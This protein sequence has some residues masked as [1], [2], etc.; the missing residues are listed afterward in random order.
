MERRIVSRRIANGSPLTDDSLW[1]RIPGQNEF[2]LADG[3]SQAPIQTV[4]QMGWDADNLYVRFQCE[5]EDILSEYTKRD[6]PLYDQEVAEL[7]LAPR[8]RCRYFEFNVSPRNVQFDSLVVN[9]L[10]GSGYLGHPEWDCAG[11]VTRVHRD[12]PPHDDLSR[13]QG[14]GPWT[15][16][17]QIPFASLS[18]KAPEAGSTWFVNFFRIKRIPAEMYSCWSPTYTSP[19]NFHVPE[20]FGHLDFE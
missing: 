2:C 19:A 3:S 7:F 5:D 20:F 16:V 18:T 10:D 12:R 8:D 9:T 13:T 15:A 1:H 6:E 4:V 11:L 17:M 14:F